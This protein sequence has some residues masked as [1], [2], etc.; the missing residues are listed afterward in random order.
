MYRNLGGGQGE[1]VLM[2][3]RLYPRKK[4]DTRW[5]YVRPDRCVAVVDI[6]DHSKATAKRKLQVQYVDFSTLSADDQNAHRRSR[7][8]QAAGR[9][10]GL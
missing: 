7:H 1:V 2:L 10:V 5:I 4:R 6:E 9:R 8:I 3:M